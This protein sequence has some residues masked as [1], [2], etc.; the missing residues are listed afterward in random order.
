MPTPTYDW[1]RL[2]CFG[3]LM[4]GLICYN[5]P[6]QDRQ[7][8]QR[9][10]RQ[11]KSIQQ[12]DPTKSSFFARSILE[13][14]KSGRSPEIRRFAYRAYSDL[15]SFGGTRVILVVRPKLPQWKEIPCLTEL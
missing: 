15:K 9:D 6:E 3:K 13:I 7:E 12:S 14:Q 2:L 11:N 5:L 10:V 8:L 1:P 4:L